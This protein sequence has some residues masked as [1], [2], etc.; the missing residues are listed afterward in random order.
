M[1][2]WESIIYDPHSEDGLWHDSSSLKNLP[3]Y[4]DVKLS[5]RLHS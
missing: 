4:V 3:H 5:I 2:P 1:T